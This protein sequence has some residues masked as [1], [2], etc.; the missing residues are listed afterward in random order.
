MPQPTRT[1]AIKTHLEAK[2][3]PDLA[4]VYNHDMEVQVNV[5]QDGGERVEG[6]F[7]GKQWLA[8]TDN[9]TTWKSFRIPYKAN[10]EP[11]YE[12][13]PMSFDLSKHVEGIGMTGWDWKNRVSRWFAYDF[14]ASDRA[15][16]YGIQRSSLTQNLVTSKMLYVVSRGYI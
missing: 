14:D 1:Q 12:D 4:G 6:E 15:L 5:A 10:T 2:T 16:G 11:E 3:W 9:L 13:K 7:R 8:W